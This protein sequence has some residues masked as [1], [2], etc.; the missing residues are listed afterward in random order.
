[1]ST[2]EMASQEVNSLAS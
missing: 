2:E 1:M